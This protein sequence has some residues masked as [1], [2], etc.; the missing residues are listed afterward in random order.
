MVAGRFWAAP[1]MLALDIARIEAGPLQS[2]WITPW[3][4]K[5]SSTQNP[6]PR[7]GAGLDDR[8]GHFTS[9]GGR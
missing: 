4:T 2:M 8:P 6:A 5:P 7:T 9:A 3:P 1:G